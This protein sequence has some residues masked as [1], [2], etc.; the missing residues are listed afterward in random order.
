M[1]Y[2]KDFVW[3]HFPKCAGSKT[4]VLFEKYF[5]NIQGLHLDPVGL[6]NDPTVAWHDSIYDR[7]NRDPSF[8]LGNR[9]LIIPI[10]RLPSWLVSRYCFEVQRTSN[11][12]HDKMK[13]LKGFFLESNGK[14]NNADFYMKKYLPEEL[15]KSNRVRFLRTEF[16][17]EDFKSIFS[18]YL[19]IKKIPDAAYATNVNASEKCLSEDFINKL[20]KLDFNLISPYWSKIQKLAY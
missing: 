9:D 2:N 18:S 15:L 5:N 14:E 12:N 10:R 17:E 16:F 3:L 7:E 20:A 8:K 6:K 4:E 11:L 19:D 1:I 13:L